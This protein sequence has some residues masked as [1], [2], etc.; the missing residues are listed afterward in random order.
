MRD[1]DVLWN[2]HFDHKESN[3]LLEV[4]K[5]QQPHKLMNTSLILTKGPP[6]F[7]MR[8]KEND[9]GI[10][11]TTGTTLDPTSL[12]IKVCLKMLLNLVLHP[13][14]SFSVLFDGSVSLTVN[15]PQSDN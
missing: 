1:S 10:I 12:Q 13:K 14:H 11:M 7:T 8:T 5:Q 9:R 2:T 4:M 15:R 6:P 3:S